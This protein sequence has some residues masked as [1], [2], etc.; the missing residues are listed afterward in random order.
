MQVFKVVVSEYKGKKLQ[1]PQYAAFC[2]DHLMG[3]C[4]S[5]TLGRINTSSG[6]VPIKEM[7]ALLAHAYLFNATLYKSPEDYHRKLVFSNDA[8]RFEG[9]T[10][11][12]LFYQALKDIAPKDYSKECVNNTYGWTGREFQINI[13]S[14]TKDTK[15]L[16][17]QIDVGDFVAKWYIIDTANSKEENGQNVLNK[18][19][20]LARMEDW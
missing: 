15:R 3:D 20:S 4:S 9:E 18:Q 6:D 17:E 14:I 2:Y 12:N 5:Y 13:L 7:C 8:T 19:D 16:Q 10:S 1:F 11:Y